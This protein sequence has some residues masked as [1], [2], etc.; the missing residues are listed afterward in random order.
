MGYRFLN[1]IRRPKFCADNF[2]GFLNLKIIHC[3]GTDGIDSMNAMTKAR[4]HV[5]KE[6][7]PVIVHANCVRIHNHSNSDNHILYRDDKELAEVKAKD[8]LVRFRKELIKSKRFTNSELEKIE[9]E[10]K[11]EM[12]EHIQN[13]CRLQ[14]LTPIRF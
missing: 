1:V 14:T 5:M 3:D 8:P 13:V 12:I 4:E 7:T 11:A 9:E 10:M 2:T 6:G